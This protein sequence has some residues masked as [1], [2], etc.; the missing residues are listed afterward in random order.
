M[1][2]PY[3]VKK[4]YLNSPFRHLGIDNDVPISEED[5][6]QKL[7]YEAQ[8]LD[9]KIAGDFELFDLLG[10]MQDYRLG[11]CYIGLYA[12]QIKKFKLYKELSNTF[13]DFCKEYFHKGA[14][15]VN[16]LIEAAS[17]V[18]E[19]ISNGYGEILPANESQVR[20][21]RTSAKKAGVDIV[22]GWQYVCDRYKHQPWKITYKTINT[23][24]C[25]EIPEE[26]QTLTKVV[27]P[28]LLVEFIQKLASRAKMGFTEYLED[29]LGAPKNTDNLSDKVKN[30]R[31]EEDTENLVREHEESLNSA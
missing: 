27:L 25:G 22:R 30:E 18:L 24:I 23:A 31:W 16:L 21:L 7:L 29:V 4:G 1:S 12:F 8:E 9:D 11:F 19:L 17:D 15:Y 13:H 28:V 3:K 10:Q 2:N 6:V 20:S 14:D 26:P 5:H